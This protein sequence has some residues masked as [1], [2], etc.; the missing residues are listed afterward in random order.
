MALMFGLWYLAAL[1]KTIEQR[2][3]GWLILVNLAGVGAGLF[4]VTTFIVFVL[5]A[6]CVFA[7]M[8]PAIMTSRCGSSQL[9]RTRPHHRMAS[10]WRL[11]HFRLSHATLWWLHF[12]PMA[13]KFLARTGPPS[14]LA[15]SAEATFGTGHRFD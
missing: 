1:V 14:P 3:F 7:R 2:S 11:M 15:D 6:L 10:V 13:S 4:E 12:F 5:P 8:A 9:E